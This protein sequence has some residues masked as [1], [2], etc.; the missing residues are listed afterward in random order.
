MKKTSKLDLK[1]N[2]RPGL[3]NNVQLHPKLI[4]FGVL[5]TTTVALPRIGATDYWYVS[6]VH[7][8]ALFV[9]F[10]ESYQ[11][12]LFIFHFPEKLENINLYVSILL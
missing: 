5:A 7:R 4:N 6:A 9:L 8:L 3:S 10:F 12:V 11:N 2:K 1:Q